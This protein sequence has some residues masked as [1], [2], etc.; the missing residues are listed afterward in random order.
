MKE[1]KQMFYFET[2][3]VRPTQEDTQWDGHVLAW[4]NGR[5][6]AVHWLSLK[7]IDNKMFDDVAAEEY[8][9]WMQMPKA[10]SPNDRNA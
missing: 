4:N 9:Y 10:P 6:M 5:W 3:K 8:P 7:L 1:H 2:S